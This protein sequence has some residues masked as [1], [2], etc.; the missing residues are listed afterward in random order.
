M[1]I[2]LLL[3]TWNFG[4]VHE[5]RALLAG[6]AAGPSGTSGV[7][8]AASP[9]AGEKA[10][11][12]VFNASA[13]GRTRLPG[14]TYELLTLEDAGVTFRVAEDGETYT[15]NAT[16]KALQYCKASGLLTLADDSGLE[17]DALD[18]APGLHS[19]RYSVK[20]GANDADRRMVL[21]ENLRGKAKPW[22]ARF[23]CT[24]IVAIPAGHALPEGFTP[25]SVVDGVTLYQTEG[26]CEGE[27][28]QEERGR[29]GFGYDPIF[30][31]AGM[32]YTMAEL[33]T[34]EKNQ[35]SHRA[36]AV[37]ATLPLLAE[38]IAIS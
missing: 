22:T 1:P 29:N 16:R 23:R 5:M 25:A 24:V 7:P 19:A 2:P 33:S 4:K 17:V 14:A 28:I 27:I 35:V 6:L 30:L 11:I 34:E 13:P 12:P 38:I 32:V 21:L 26:T 15:E 37:K 31:M 18:G 8:P 9:S 36:R 10:S 20:P 3:A